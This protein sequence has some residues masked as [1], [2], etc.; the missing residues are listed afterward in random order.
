[1]KYVTLYR[2]DFNNPLYGDVFNLMLEDLG[3]ETH[4]LVAG[5]NIDRE[6]QSVDLVVVSTEVTK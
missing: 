5:R 2:E 6:I 3:I 1:M 4:T